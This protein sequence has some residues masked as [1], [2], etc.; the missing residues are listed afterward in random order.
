MAS[1]RELWILLRA[2]DEASRVVSSFSKNV[3]AAALA[4]QAAQKSAEASAIRQ[5]AQMVRANSATAQQIRA[6][7]ENV[8]ALEKQARANT[9]AAARAREFRAEQLKAVEGTIRANNVHASNLERQARALSLAAAMGDEQR[10]SLIRVTGATNEQIEA[11]DKNIAALRKRAATL[12]AE[13]AVARGASNSMMAQLQKEQTGL[14]GSIRSYER[15]AAVIRAQAA[16]MRNQAAE[17]KISLDSQVR[18]LTNQAAAL[19]RQAN[20]MRKAAAAARA[21]DIRM[22]AL[23]D[24][25]GKVSEASTVMAF[26]LGAIG[27]GGL[28]GL[29][30]AIDTTIAYEKQVRH[31]ATQVDGFGASLEEI[32]DIGKRVAN[33]I[34]VPFETIQPALFDIFSSME[35]S[36]KDAERLLHA[37]SKAAVAGQVEIQDV[38]RATIGLLNAFGRPAKDVN[39]ILDM[40]FQLIQEGIGTYEEWNQRI[41]LVTPSAVRAGQSIEMMMAALATATRMGMSAA[42]SGTAVARAM[43]A[44]SHPAAVKNLEQLGVKVRDAHG[45]FRPMNQVLREFRDVLMKMPEK[46]RLEAILNVFKGAGGTIEARRFLQN[47]LLGKDGVEQ[48]D[49]ALQDLEGSAGSME[50]A[51]AIMAD[52]TSSKTELLRNKWQLLKEAIGKAL[53]PAFDNLIDRM[54]DLLDWF[55][56]LPQG[57]KNTISQFLLW[58]SVIAIVLGSMFAFVGVAAVFIAAIGTIGV[59]AA[60]ALGVLI[61]LPV[62]ILAVGVAFYKAYQKSQTFRDM[63]NGLGDTIREFW[64]IIKSTADRIK[65][66]WDKNVVPPLRKTGEIIEEKVL[67][68]LRDFADMVKNEVLPKVEEA[69]RIIGDFADG[70][71][72][73]VG[74]VIE[75]TVNPALEKMAGWWDKNGEKLMPLIKILAQVV[76]WALIAGVVLG[77]VLAVVLVGPIVAAFT[78]AGLAA[79]LFWMALVE[80]TDTAKE[81]WDNLQRLWD[82]LQTIGTQAGGMFQEAWAQIQMFFNNLLIEVQQL[83]DRIM[84]FLTSLPGRLQGLFAQALGAA[85]YAIGFGLG[86]IFGMFT[87][88]PTRVGG[89]LS[90]LPSRMAGIF[91][92]AF[93]SA[94]GVV[95]IGSGRVLSLFTQLPVRAGAAVGILWN[96]LSGHFELSRSGAVNSA[97]RLLSGYINIMRTL[98]TRAVTAIGSLRQR[99]IGYFL[100]SGSWLVGAGQ[101]IIRGVIS[102]IGQMIGGGVEAARNAAR[103]MVQGFMDAL[104]IG[105]PSKVFAEMGKFSIQGYAKGLIQEAKMAANTVARTSTDIMTAGMPVATGPSLGF[106]GGGTAGVGFG[107]VEGGRVFNQTINIT[108]NEI[109]PRRNAAELGY[110]LEGRLR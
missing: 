105:S 66:S 92:R 93:V 82:L 45:R 94:V 24:T 7:N 3:R 103:R 23:I 8:V 63:V 40:Q 31:T 58:G 62:A 81:A 98:P 32:S 78:L 12:N 90:S 18:S 11:I 91:Q 110:E 102:G 25:M 77:A 64:G 96:R 50:S 53:L 34:A 5:Q 48:F 22:R 29:K 36:M 97:Q 65:T 88:V 109:D 27:V 72:K 68:P 89:L 76:K 4:A 73:K 28:V 16:Q 104:R 67:P 41:G 21:H 39:K 35:V 43:D 101:N 14:D 54:S 42:R 13:A 2:R 86:T 33:E 83:P 46:K 49:R 52:S 30:Q 61:L 26:G 69:S 71:L 75:N 79:Q 95:A 60:V 70:T 74:D 19:D 1:T 56:K 10:D 107:G 6:I 38:S 37:F 106:A 84:G 80:M 47:I 55:N 108:T 99:I 57:T 44:M 85:A 9:A 17:L 51:Y 100:G 59:G 20:A 15:R 87:G